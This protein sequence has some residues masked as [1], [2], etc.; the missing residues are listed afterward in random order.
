M[1]K[2]IAWILMLCMVMGL[3]CGCSDT[4]SSSD[5]RSNR[6]DRDKEKVE[7]RV[8]DEDRDEEDRDDEDWDDEVDEEKDKPTKMNLVVYDEN[9]VKVTV[10][11]MDDGYSGKEVKIQVE[12]NTEHNIALSG[13]LFVVNG[14]TMD[15]WLYASVAAGKKTN[16]YI[17]FYNETLDEAGVEELATVACVDSCIVD[18]DSFETLF[19]APFAFETSIADGYVQEID[20]SGEVLFQESG[21]TIIGK[22]ISEN[23]LGKRV[24]VL[25]KNETGKDIMVVSDEAY[26]DGLTVDG[27]MYDEVEADT[28][29][30]CVLDIYATT[31]EEN[32]IEEVNAVSFFVEV[33][34]TDS[35]ETICE[36]DELTVTAN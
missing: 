18:T 16:D 6:K 17:T 23:S 4:D 31:L 19:E 33:R 7:D 1:K 35:W 8:D 15:G 5:R 10:T 34:Y 12:N 27:W 29:R 9:G 36:T 26:I 3:L 30:F 13:D 2:L 21:V 22:T 20:D 28:V 14:I 11:G 24:I 32:E 25:V